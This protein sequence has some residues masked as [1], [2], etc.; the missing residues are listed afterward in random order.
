MTNGAR[1]LTDVDGARAFTAV[2][3]REVGGARGLTAVNTYYRGK[4]DLV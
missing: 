3:E 1:A 4:R 2:D